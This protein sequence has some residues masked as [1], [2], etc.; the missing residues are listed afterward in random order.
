MT[1]NG[2]ARICARQNSTGKRKDLYIHRLVAENFIPNPHYKQYA[3]HKNTIRNDNRVEN[4]EWCTAKENIEYTLQV[5][6]VIRNPDNG[7]YISNYTY[8]A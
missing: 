1:T 5:N 7:Q 8:K 3:N 6:H 2:Y 4:L